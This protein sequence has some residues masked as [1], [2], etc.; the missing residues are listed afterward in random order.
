MKQEKDVITQVVSKNRWGNPEIIKKDFLLIPLFIFFQILTPIIIVFGVLGVT[1][2]V[3]QQPPPFYFSSI[4]T[5]L[6]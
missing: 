1:A 3:T 5:T 4:I 2:M 6:N